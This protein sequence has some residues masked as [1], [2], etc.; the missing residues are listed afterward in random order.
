MQYDI[1][2]SYSRRDDKQGRISALKGLY[3]RLSKGE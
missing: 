3:E 2:V 1:I